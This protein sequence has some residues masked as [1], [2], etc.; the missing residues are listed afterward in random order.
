MQG[1]FIPDLLTSIWRPDICVWRLLLTNYLLAPKK[2]LQ[3]PLWP[4]SKIFWQK[5][6]ISL[7]VPMSVNTSCE[8]VLSMCS[9]YS[10]TTVPVTY[11][12]FYKQ[13]NWL[14][15]ESI[16]GHKQNR[17]RKYLLIAMFCD[18]PRNFQRKLP[19]VSQSFQELCCGV[20]CL[21]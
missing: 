2:S 17:N 12:V 1:A 18:W 6:C 5:H 9:T 13:W 10:H 15:P 21:V 3:G 4:S 7:L 11:N 19:A 14:V 8:A 16:R 20:K